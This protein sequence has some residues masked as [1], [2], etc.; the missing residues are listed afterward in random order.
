MAHGPT[1]HC[2]LNG[3]DKEIIFLH[4]DMIRIAISH[5]FLKQLAGIDSTKRCAIDCELNEVKKRIAPGESY[6]FY[7]HE[8]PIFN[9]TPIN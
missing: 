3:Q 2:K 9:I 4:K 8:K 5:E 7:H 1:L 6:Y